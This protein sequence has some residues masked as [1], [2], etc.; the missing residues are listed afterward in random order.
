MTMELEKKLDV[1]G[2]EAKVEQ[3]DFLEEIKQETLFSPS[4]IYNA[5]TG[6]G[7]VP[8]M[9]ILLSNAC[10]NN[11]LYCACREKRD[12][13]KMTFQPDEL[14]K[15]FIDVYRKHIVQG[16]FISSVITNNPV[17]SMDKIID[18][19]EILRKKFKYGGY[20]HLKVLPGCEY[21]QIE[22]ACKLASRVSINMEAP[23]QN[24]LD[25]V[26]PQKRLQEDLVPRLFH[27]GEYSRQ[28]GEPYMP[29]GITTQ[30]I[31][32]CSN[33]SDREILNMSYD[34]YKKKTVDKV[35]Y[36]PFVPIKGTPMENVSPVH[37]LRKYR[38]YQADTLIRH[39]KFQ[40]EEL[41]FTS[42]GVLPLTTDPKLAWV[43]NNLG[44]FPVDVM[45]ANFSQLIRVPGIGMKSAR[46]IIS[47]RKHTT[48]RNLRDLQKLGVVVKQAKKFI[49]V[50]GKPYNDLEGVQLSLFD[51]V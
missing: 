6:R 5:S 25:V 44:G 31:V 41:V 38:L 14:A 15:L 2:S 47:I 30:F 21:K 29:A 46:N 23:S 51:I 35:H 48:P 13:A 10:R 4:W 37:P 1:L 12:S 45:K 34:F 9:K 7:T 26:A 49:T 8:I 33:D 17:E 19:A 20:L 28:L 27:I 40:P 43:Q 11:C 18:T 32:G 24:I 16:L 36:S 22:A 50:N 42:T 39:Y 3:C